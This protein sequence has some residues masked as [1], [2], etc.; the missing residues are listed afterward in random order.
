[1]ELARFISVTGQS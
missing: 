1:L